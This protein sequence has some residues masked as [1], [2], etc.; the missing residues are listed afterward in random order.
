MV[1]SHMFVDHNYSQCLLIFYRFIYVA[2]THTHESH[3][4]MNSMSPLLIEIM[5]TRY[6]PSLLIIT[7]QIIQQFIILLGRL[8]KVTLWLM[9]DSCT[10]VVLLISKRCQFF[11]HDI[12]YWTTTPKRF[13]KFEDID[14]Y[15]NVTIVKKIEFA[16]TCQLV[17]LFFPWFSFLT[18]Y[19]GFHVKL[20]FEIKLWYHGNV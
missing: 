7:V 3:D 16:P 4:E 9:G 5:M 15:V 11:F 20:T 12:A 14:K 19:F 6:Q 1:I 2:S 10:C 18:P 17:P 8:A 13:E